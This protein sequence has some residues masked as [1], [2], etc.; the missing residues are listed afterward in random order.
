MQNIMIGIKRFLKNR[1]TVTI[2]AILLILGILYWA[3]YYRIK[4]ATEPV[5][6][7]YAVKAI[8]PRTLITSDMVSTRKVPGGVVKNSKVL[9]RSSNIIGKYVSNDSVIPEGG[10][11]YE[12]MVVEW[13]ELPTSLYANIPDGN[14]VVLLSVN[15]DKTFGNSIFPGNY[16]DLYYYYEGGQNTNRKKVLGKFIESIKVLAVTDSNGNSVFETIDEPLTPAYLMFSVPDDVYVLIRKAQST[17]IDRIIP[18]QRNAAYSQN[19][20]PTRVVSSKIQELIENNTVADEIIYQGMSVI[21]N[22]PS[23]NKGE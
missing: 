16:I 21:G 5:S 18:V 7:P 20:K 1:N 8:G 3:Y 23:T 11:F 2:F 9:M 17:G 6:V 13:E 19:P 15:L 10:L 14:T 12:D 22:A 4:K